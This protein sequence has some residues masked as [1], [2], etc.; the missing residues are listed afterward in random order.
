MTVL[1]KGDLVF[2]IQRSI[3]IWDTTTYLGQVKRTINAH[4]DFV[5]SICLFPNGNLASDLRINLLKYGI[6]P[7][8]H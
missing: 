6:Q 8:G 3:N 5:R 7:I 1:K 2:S 4:F